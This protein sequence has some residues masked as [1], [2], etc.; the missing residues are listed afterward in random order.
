M[1]AEP[2]MVD[3]LMNMHKL[4]E[5]VGRRIDDVK[6]KGLDAEVLQR[7]A[8]MYRKKLNEM[9]NRFC[10]SNSFQCSSAYVVTRAK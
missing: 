1:P 10:A 6:A 5:L 4:I 9:E 7:S 2:S 8:D 3:E